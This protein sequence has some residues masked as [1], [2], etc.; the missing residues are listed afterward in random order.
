MKMFLR[1]LHLLSFI[2]IFLLLSNIEKVII[3]LFTN[4]RRFYCIF[5]SYHRVSVVIVVVGYSNFG[6][7]ICCSLDSNSTTRLEV[8]H[9]FAALF[10][11]DIIYMK[12]KYDMENT[13]E[14]GFLGRV[15]NSEKHWNCCYFDIIY[16]SVFDSSTTTHCAPWKDCCLE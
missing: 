14:E 4:C 1:F 13:A 2:G 8:F 10:K 3:I 5:L 7:L 6:F 15:V 16:I 9:S 11:R 12:N